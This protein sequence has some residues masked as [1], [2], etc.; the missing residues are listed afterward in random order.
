[1]DE[2]ILSSMVHS[3]SVIDRKQRKR[4]GLIDACLKLKQQ[5]PAYDELIMNTLTLLGVTE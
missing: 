5:S 2:S 1:M 3:E 4:L